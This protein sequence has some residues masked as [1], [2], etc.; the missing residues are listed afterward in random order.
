MAEAPVSVPTPFYADLSKKAND[1][2]SKG[3]HFGLIKLDLKTK[4]ASGVEF[5]SG[6][7][8]NQESGKVFGSLSSKYA[9]KDYG[10]T[11]TEKWNTDNTLATDITI[12]DKIAKGLKVTLE[13]TFAPQTG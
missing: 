11:F 3:Y 10:L 5:T 2:F 7:V 1:V 4:S 6:I 12:Q 8:S 13:G 9:V